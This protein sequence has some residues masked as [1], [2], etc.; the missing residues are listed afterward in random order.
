ME[1]TRLQEAYSI[2]KIDS[3]TPYSTAYGR[4]RRLAKET[5]PDKGGDGEAFKALSEAWQAAKATLPKHK[6]GLPRSSLGVS[7]RVTLFYAP[8][9]NLYLR[10]T[11]G[12]DGYSMPL[13]YIKTG[14]DTY[15][16]KKGGAGSKESHC[17]L[18]EDDLVLEHGI[19]CT[20]EIWSKS[21]DTL[22]WWEPWNPPRKETT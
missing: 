1:R 11:V 16:I 2:L 19:N 4:Y 22:K 20:V 12:D 14:K 5:H 3:H 6:G 15:E 9:P 17:D 7:R 21:V 13:N 18:G 10:M 8:A